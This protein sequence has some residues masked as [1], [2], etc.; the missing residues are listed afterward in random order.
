M[1]IPHSYHK[2]DI[3]PWPIQ[4]SGSLQTMAQGQVSWKTKGETKGIKIIGQNLVVIKTLWLKDVVREG[5]A[6]YHTK[7]VAKGIE[8][9]FYLFLLSE[10]KIFFSIFWTYFHSSQNPSVEIQFWPPKG[11]NAVDYLSLPLLNSVLLQG[12]GFIASGA[13][14]DLYRNEKGLTIKGLIGCKVLTQIFLSVQIVEYK[15][16]EFTISD[17][18][19]G[20]IFFLGTGVHGFHILCSILLTLVATYR[21]YKDS[22]TSEHALIL[23]FALIYYHL[24]DV[25]WL[26]LYIIF[27]YWGT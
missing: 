18:V 21:I 23:D 9:A 17:S 22:I 27:Y 19:Y 15:Y 10:I 13:H 3:S 20:S 2:V 16:S 1:R 24:V 8:L 25:V 12:G 7:A 5:K 4:K 26:F 14:A 11:I 6:G